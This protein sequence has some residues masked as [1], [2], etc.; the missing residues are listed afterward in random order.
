[1]EHTKHSKMIGLAFAT[2]LTTVLAACDASSDRVAEDGA[3]P[4]AEIE[5][6]RSTQPATSIGNPE[7]AAGGRVRS[8]ERAAE[9]DPPGT[10][11]REPRPSTAP[12]AAPSPSADMRAADAS[13]TDEHAGHDMGSMPD[14]NMG[15][16]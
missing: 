15:N 13:P 8:A 1:M 3:T 4:V 11:E 9:I 16:E 2:L 14:H 7:P 12:T 6:A 10:A 5:T